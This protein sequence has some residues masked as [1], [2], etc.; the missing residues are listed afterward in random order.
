MQC[1]NFDSENLIGNVHNESLRCRSTTVIN[2]EV[3]L[4]WNQTRK[5]KTEIHFSKI[6]TFCSL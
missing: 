3:K 4:N 6:I 2:F 1:Y 5:A